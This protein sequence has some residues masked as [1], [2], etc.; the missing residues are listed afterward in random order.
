MVEEERKV[1]KDVSKT[2]EAKVVE[3]LVHYDLKEQSSN[4]FFLTCS[5]LIERKKTELIEFLTAN[6]E[7]FVWTPYEIPG[8]D[9]SFIEHKMNIIPEARLVM[10]REMRSATEY[11][12]TMIEE[13]DKL[14]EV[15]AITEILYPS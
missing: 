10:Q 4:C 11:V 12:N 1:L 8:I 2:L 6:I 14:N 3:D 7:V 15:S 13:V 9:P 5:N